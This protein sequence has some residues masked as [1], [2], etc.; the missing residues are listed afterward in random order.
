MG[1]KSIKPCSRR[2]RST[3]RRRTKRG[4]C[5]RKLPVVKCQSA[6]DRSTI[7]RF[8]HPIPSSF[9]V[10]TA[11]YHP[12]LLACNGAPRYVSICCTT[13][14]SVTLAMSHA[15]PRLPQSPPLP[16]EVST[17]CSYGLSATFACTNRTPLV[18][19]AILSARSSNTVY[20][21]DFW[22]LFVTRG[23]IW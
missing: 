22:N 18:I 11:R 1:L 5:C 3:P 23:S 17:I 6:G 9:N 12:V 21:F 10:F 19:L 8:F 7:V 20:D 13:H 14:T 15:A 16:V 2:A 4:M